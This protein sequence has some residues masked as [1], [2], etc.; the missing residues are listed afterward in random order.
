MNGFGAAILI[1]GAILLLA[2]VA[3]ALI[4]ASEQIAD[5]PADELA[6]VPAG[7]VAVDCRI[8]SNIGNEACNLAVYSF[9][10]LSVL[11]A[12][13]LVAC[14]ICAFAALLFG[15]AAGVTR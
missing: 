13:L 14:V 7:N 2:F 9:N 6:V 12:I 10:A 4:P 5:F 15:L 1:I 8:A 3:F 11:L